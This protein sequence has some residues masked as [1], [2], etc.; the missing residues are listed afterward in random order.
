MTAITPSNF[1]DD[2]GHRQN[3]QGVQKVKLANFYDDHGHRE[4][5]Q[6]VPH[7]TPAALPLPPL[8]EG[9]Q[10]GVR[11]NPSYAPKKLRSAIARHSLSC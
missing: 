2:H 11:Q 9:P 1:H 6:E 8:A 10:E 5:Q 4:N 3:Q 7:P